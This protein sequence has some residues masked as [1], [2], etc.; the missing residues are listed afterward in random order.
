MGKKH[1]CFFRTAETGNRTPNPVKGS[2]ANHYPRA[3]APNHHVGPS[4]L[5]AAQAI[6][7]KPEPDSESQ[8]WL[9]T[10]DGVVEPVWSIGLILPSSLIKLLDICDTENDNDENDCTDAEPNLEDDVEINYDD[11][12]TENDY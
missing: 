8:E 12:L 10:D 2:G 4:L 6:F 11:M 1:F 5:H 3:P 7:E 9:R